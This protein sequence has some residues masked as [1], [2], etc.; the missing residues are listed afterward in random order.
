MSDEPIAYS[1]PRPSEAAAP[2][3]RPERTQKAQPA[4][5]SSRPRKKKTRNNA[6]KPTGPR[7]PL[8]AALLS[9]SQTA[10]VR[11][12]D[13]SQR[14]WVFF[15]SQDG[16]HLTFSS[17]GLIPSD[18][19]IPFAGNLP[20]DGLKTGDIILD[21]KGSDWRVVQRFVFLSLARS[22]P[23]KSVY[24]LE[25]ILTPEDITQALSPQE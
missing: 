19:E 21:S 5:S 10:G 12:V 16:S 20:P 1:A 15:A 11:Q 24:V 13:P 3:P 14:Q 8:S 23:A 17:G 2:T 9:Q 7:F 18:I 22:R 25:P 6:Q 4:P